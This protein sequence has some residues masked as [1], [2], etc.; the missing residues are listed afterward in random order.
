MVSLILLNNTGNLTKKQSRDY[1]Q[2]VAQAPSM[3]HPHTPI[4]AGGR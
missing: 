1:S 2:I 3:D 4:F